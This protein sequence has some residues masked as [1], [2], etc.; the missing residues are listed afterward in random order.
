[1]KLRLALAAL[2]CLT[3]T[4]SQPIDAAPAHF[5]AEKAPAIVLIL[6]HAEKPIDDKASDLAPQG[7][8][9][10]MALPG[11]FFPQSGSSVPRFPRPDALFATAV[12][13]HS[14]RPI[15]TITP[16]SQAL[17]L[18]INRDFED[19]ETGSIAK[20]VLS[21]RYAGKTVLICWHH[22]EIHNIAKAFGVADAP[23]WK[24]E[25][26]DQVW[27]IEWHDGQA[28]LTILPQQLMPGDSTR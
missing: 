6:R 28:V 16:L 27:Q 12:S 20:E 13:K 18:P 19:A 3:L 23:K 7:Y 21:G 11:L 10:A 14:N 17:H 9:R 24:E 5:V 25:V 2:L 1:M 4:A 8:K 26:F 15:E 22:G